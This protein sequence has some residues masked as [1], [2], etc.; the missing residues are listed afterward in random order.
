MSPHGQE[1]KK[2]NPDDVHNSL[3]GF[4]PVLIEKNLPD[5]L[6]NKG[7]LMMKTTLVWTMILFTLSLSIGLQHTAAVDTSEWGL[8]EG[9]K[10]RLGKGHINE[11]AYSP[12]GTLLAVASR[13]GIWLYD[14][15]TLQERALLTGH[16]SGVNSVSFSPDGKTIASGSDDSTVRLWDVATASQ[17]GTLTGDTANVTSVAFSP[18][19]TTIASVGWNEVHLW[20]VATATMTA[21]LQY[22][23]DVGSIAF[24]PDG[25]T[26]A[27]AVNENGTVHLWDVVTGT[28][29][30]TLMVEIGWV[31]G[32]A[33]SPDGTTIASGSPREVLLWDVATA[34]QKGTLTGT[35]GISL[36]FSPDGT[37]LASSGWPDV[38]LYDVATATQAGTLQHTGLVNSVVFSP[39][40]RTI[41][42][43]SSDEVLLWDVAT[44]TH[45][46]TLTGYTDWVNSVVFSPDGNTIA[47][48][49]S[50]EVRLW[51]MATATQKETF[52]GHTDWVYSV[53]FSPDG[54]TIATGSN[55]NTVRLWDVATATQKAI[56]TEHTDW[57]ESVAFSPD[58]TTIATGSNDNTVRLWDV[59]TATQ[60]AIL[61][62]HTDW[63]ESVAFSPD[64]KTIAS[65]SRDNTV[66]LWN[67][68]TATQT[69]ALQHTSWVNS[70][71][72][73]PDGNTIATG[74]NDRTVYLWDV[75][76]A[77]QK[78]TL[79]GH[80][81][82]VNS[83]AFSPDGNSIASGS[84]GEVRL[85]DV[86]TDKLK[87]TLTGHTNWV[88]S[89]AFSPDGNSLI[90]GSADGTVLLWD[91]TLYLDIAP[92]IPVPTD[93]ATVRLTP[94]TTEVLYVGEQIMLDLNVTNGENVAGYQATI[95]FDETVLR[96]V[97]SANADFLLPD[98]YIGTPIVS[99][100]TVTIAATSLVRESNGDG[101]LA[102]LTFEIVGQKSSAVTLTEVL[103]SD[104]EGMLTRP[105][106]EST[107]LIV[108]VYLKEDVNR[109]GVVDI[110]D[111]MLVDADLTQIGEY[112]TDV[113]E[114]GVVNI[115]DLVLVAE[116]QSSNAT[117]AS[118]ALS[119][120][121]AFALSK[122]EVE[123]WL[124][125]A[126]QLNLTDPKSLRGI[127][128]L[129][130]LLLTIAP[131]ETALLAN[132]P[133]PFNPETWIPYQL[134]KPANIKLTIYAADGKLIRTLTLGH[135]AAGVYHSRNRAAYWNGK[136]EAG[137]SVASGVYFYTL[138]A[139]DFSATRKLLIL[140]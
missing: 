130:Q 125:E 122:A 65:G 71:S 84:F 7:V 42:S 128:F 19:G 124:Q 72:F 41:T 57:V 129:E 110:Q 22:E 15:D 131:E 44:A 26:I 67:V 114:D 136:N 104:S 79:T 118:L 135:Q 5:F 93:D 75:V 116:A 87:G 86:A 1:N 45:K 121:K 119:H 60:K 140:K 134:A 46:H 73:S 32:I 92:E 27:S 91:L 6:A 39:D 25:T 38:R 96:Y 88:N 49:S 59:A 111:L 123:M 17:K 138:T 64:G 113:N 66:R 105:R 8:P 24:S 101:T 69:V 43:A 33:F 82:W 54:T 53:A 132:Y 112:A 115:A 50:D 56:L 21:I 52:T 137:E 9:A 2:P 51:D 98:T 89:V 55:D 133:N 23:G 139:G 70:I 74:T 11:I 109:D 100:N 77:T 48:A 37:T 34:T 107:E 94:H 106:I 16:T 90:S 29:K 78:G 99:G 4:I 127:R 108:T 36:A 68:A 31:N 58:G 10:A 62:G 126:K 14:T 76:T 30:A 3:S 28:Q 35:P 47:S 102:T 117:A 103:F 18:D 97:S 80:R 83:V 61:T 120:A 85:W 95:Q 20:D 12:D 63:V 40:G 81:S 13:I